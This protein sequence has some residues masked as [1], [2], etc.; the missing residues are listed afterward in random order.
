MFPNTFASRK[1]R[2]LMHKPAISFPAEAQ[3]GDI[4]MIKKIIKCFQ[5]KD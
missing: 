5:K 3:T 4:I 2:I 1:R